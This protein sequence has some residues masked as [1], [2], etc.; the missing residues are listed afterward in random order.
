[1]DFY[2]AL[3]AQAAPVTI[4]PAET[5][6]FSKPG[7]GLDPRLFRNNKFIPAI[8]S[9]VLRILF[10]HLRRHY[11]SPESFTTVWIAGS[12][13]SYQW[14]AARS[15]ADLDCLIGINYLAFRQSNPDYKGF[16]DQEI[17]SMFNEDFSKE[18]QPL[19]TNFLEAFELTFYANVRTDIKSIKPYA[20]YSLTQDDWT[21]QPEIKSPPSNKGWELKVSKDV[22]MTT[23]ILSRY[24]KALSDIAAASNDSARRNA[25]SAL[26]LAIDQGSA[27]FDDIHHGRKYAF[28]PSGQGYSDIANY[29]WQS[30]KSAG[31]VQALK[32]LKDISTKGRKEFE[33]QTYGME[34][35]EARTLVRRALSANTKR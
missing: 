1:M 27:L 28:S 25:E 4:E 31:T 22:S 35:P 15:P 11:Y 29:R 30:G 5:S 13:V 23:E 20:A 26:K 9:A 7:A 33:A 10:E 34:L 6:Y 21:V 14:T 18:L 16:S 19:T 3:V 2:D 17:A 12:A 24:S 32:K 8:R